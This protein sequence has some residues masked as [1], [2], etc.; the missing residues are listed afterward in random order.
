[1]LV[2]MKGCRIIKNTGRQLQSWRSCG[3]LSKGV[4]V[5]SGR[6]GRRNQMNE[7]KA[8]VGV[9]PRKEGAMRNY[10]MIMIIIGYY[11]QSN[12]N[13]VIIMIIAL[14][15][16]SVRLCTRPL[17]NSSTIRSLRSTLHHFPS[18]SP[19]LCCHHGAL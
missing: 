4:V 19:S 2:W 16:P 6:I 14:P 1:M 18:L 11:L 7:E 15:F 5:F 8:A 13:H 3:I 12:I 17:L 10:Y 9:N